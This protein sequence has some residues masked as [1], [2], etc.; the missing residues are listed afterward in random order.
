MKPYM[1]THT[2]IYIQ[3]DILLIQE[4]CRMYSPESNMQQVHNGGV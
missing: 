4:L 2:S 1:H 3:T